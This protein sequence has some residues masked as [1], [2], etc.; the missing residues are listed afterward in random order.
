MGLKYRDPITGEYVKYNF[1]LIKGEP[2]VDPEVIDHL[3][4]R[5]KKVE[6][7]M[8]GFINLKSYQHLVVGGDW[9]NAF[10]QAISV[11]SEG[12]TLYI[13]SGVYT[14]SEP[15]SIEGGSHYTKGGITLIGENKANTIIKSN[16]DIDCLVEIN[17]SKSQGYNIRLESLHLDGSHCNIG[18]RVTGALAK[19]TFNNLIITGH[20]TGL[21]F[22]DDIW[23]NQ[24][25]DLMIYSQEQGLMMLKH[26]TSNKFSNIFVYG[27]GTTG[28]QLS[29]TYTFADNLACDDNSGIAYKFRFCDFVVG[30]LGNETNSG[31]MSV[32]IQNGRVSI[33]NLTIFANRLVPGFT[34]VHCHDGYCS[35][36]QYVVNSADSYVCEGGKLFNFGTHA[37]VV[38]NHISN[39]NVTFNG[40][41]VGEGSNRLK[42]SNLSTRVDGTQIR[43]YIGNVKNLE[44]TVPNMP[45]TLP[46]VAITWCDHH[47][48]VVDG[49]DVQW[50]QPFP[51]GTL[52]ICRKPQNNVVAYLRTDDTAVATRDCT[53]LKI[54]G[55]A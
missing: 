18:V 5:V 14:I 46:N 7:Q 23:Q 15:L 47:P 44:A 13:P 40:Q 53:W 26:G 41:L 43:P 32:E 6:T 19:S 52:Y 11:M 27:T 1:P 54:T 12:G 2:G 8:E 37:E 35:I 45:F 50:Q 9:S 22:E 42:I 51:Q 55:T 48:N 33:H 3:T 49:Q 25:N 24:F 17:K 29:G 38:I 20:N 4:D 10:K 30:S 28:F 39:T 34:G 31:S 21:N 16:T 36:D